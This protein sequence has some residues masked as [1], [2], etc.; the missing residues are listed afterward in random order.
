MSLAE[1]I[2]AWEGLMRYNNG[3]FN[4]TI[5]STFKTVTLQDLKRFGTNALPKNQ[6]AYLIVNSKP[7]SAIVPFAEYEELM[8]MIEDIDDLRVIE[9]RKNDGFV[10]WEKVFPKKKRK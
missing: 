9:E 1:S 10:S 7:Q 3:T 4:N 5:M 8:E 2:I 6:V